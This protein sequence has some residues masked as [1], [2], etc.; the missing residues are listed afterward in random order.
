MRKTVLI[1]MIIVAV[2]PLSAGIRWDSSAT[3]S[4]VFDAYVGEFLNVTLDIISNNGFEGSPFDLT[5]KD[6][7]PRN[8]DPPAGYGRRIAVW[9]LMTNA[10]YRK[11]TISATPL[12]NTTDSSCQV[13]Y[14]LAMMLNGYSN[15]LRTNVQDVIYVYSGYEPTVIEQGSVGAPEKIDNWVLPAEGQASN[16][17][18][19]ST[20]QDVRI[21]LMKPDGSL[22]TAEE[23]DLWADGLYQ[24]TITITITGGVN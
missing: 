22:Y 20:E 13:N 4:I 2:M 16:M 19:I 14:R 12:V 6:V 11:L 8:P 9:D 23:R 15:A 5:S 1:L 21:L 3:G 17:P 24:A 10:D 7:W 18:Y